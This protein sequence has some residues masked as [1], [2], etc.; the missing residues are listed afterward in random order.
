MKY[1]LAML[2]ANDGRIT[3]TVIIKSFIS[4]LFNGEPCASIPSA[5]DVKIDKIPITP[6][7]IDA[8]MNIFVAIFCIN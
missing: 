1:L 4:N 5:G 3:K 7:A 8:P 2:R 6:K